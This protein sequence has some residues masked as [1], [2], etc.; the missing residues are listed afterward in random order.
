ML[1]EMGSATANVYTDDPEK[2]KPT[3]RQQEEWA[4]KARQARGLLG[5]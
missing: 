3:K 2:F 1:R 4:E 5:I